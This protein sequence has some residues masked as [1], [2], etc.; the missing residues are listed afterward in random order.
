MRPESEETSVEP[1]QKLPTPKAK[2]VKALPKVAPTP[3][4]IPAKAASSPKVIPQKSTTPPAFHTLKPI[5]KK[6][7]AVPAKNPVIQHEGGD[8]SETTIIR[9]T[10]K[11]RTNIFGAMLTAIREFGHNFK[12][13]WKRANQPLYVVPD[14]N[15]RKG[16][17]QQ[18]TSQTGK[19]FTSDYE[20]LKERLRQRAEAPVIDEPDII[21]TPQTE[22]G[23]ALL[24]GEVTT[25]PPITPIT[26]VVFEPKRSI[27]TETPAP[28]PVRET[29]E[30][31]TAT[32]TPPPPVPPPAAPTVIPTPVVPPAPVPP[33]VP[34]PP[35]NP[36]PPPA[37]VIRSTPPPAPTTPATP[38]PP[39]VAT[40]ALADE[41]AAPS[42]PI[43]DTVSTTDSVDTSVRPHWSFNT[44]STNTIT[45]GIVAAVV[46]LAVLGIGTTA[47]VRYIMTE[48]A[49]PA[50]TVAPI[51]PLTTAPLV[52][53]PYTITDAESL[54]TTIT[55]ALRADVAAAEIVV[56]DQAGTPWTPAQIFAAL[57][58]SAG[59]GFQAS[60]EAVRL[61]RTG[62]QTYGV[63]FIFSNPTQ[64]RGN[65]LTWEPDM[66]TELDFLFPG[67]TAS[68]F[69]DQTHA[70]VDLRVAAPGITYGFINERTGIITSSPEQFITVQS[71]LIE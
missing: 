16:V 27:T 25:A 20:R 52:P 3:T 43:T 8:Y 17:I 15:R 28:T 58:V 67:T 37:P 36:A 22:P 12:K 45:L 14:T 31:M 6:I 47:L 51:P 30:T 1:D 4:P 32:H 64:V 48:S 63:V 13:F 33:V 40:T 23:F 21:W 61:V 42:A 11:R 68:R 53:L 59:T 46:V 65:L 5:E 7:P 55:T 29:P 35:T 41:A 39:V 44:L 57:N 50:V 70:G 38:P 9:D 2:G 56:V 34:A 26:N 10:V 18:A 19:T 24:E 49:T 69:V 62:P 54:A 71:T 66:G 60:V